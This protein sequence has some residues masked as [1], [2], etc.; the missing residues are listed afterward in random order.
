VVN[1]AETVKAERAACAQIATPWARARLRLR[2]SGSGMRYAPGGTLETAIRV[3]ANRRSS[4]MTDDTLYPD[5][6]DPLD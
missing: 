6:H 5:M 4:P 1:Q 2:L 3:R